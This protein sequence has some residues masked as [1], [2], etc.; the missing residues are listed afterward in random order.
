[1]KRKLLCWYAVCCYALIFSQTPSATCDLGDVTGHIL[2]CG[3]DSTYISGST[4]GQDDNGGNS[5]PDVYY[6]FEST[7]LKTVHISLCLTPVGVDFQLKV[8]SDCSLTNLVAIN[9]DAG[10]FCG[11][12]PTVSFQ[13]DGFSTYVIMVE[14]ADN[15]EGDSEGAF[16][17]ASWCTDPII[18]PPTVTGVTCNIVGS[19]DR[20]VYSE[21]FD[22]NTGWTGDVIYSG[23]DNGYWELVTSPPTQ[24][25]FTGPSAPFS[26]SNYLRYEATTTGGDPAP[27]SASIISQ[28]ID[29]SEYESG[30]ELSFYMHAFG[31]DM[32]TLD[33]NIYDSVDAE[34]D[35]LWEWSGQYQSTYAEDWYEVGIDISSYI[36]Q[37]V[38]LQFIQTRVVGNHGDMSIDLLEITACDS[39]PLNDECSTAQLITDTPYSET[40]D[41]SFAT[42]NT[43]FVTSCSSGMNDGVWYTFTAGASGTIDID[44]TNVI[45]WD[46]AIAVYSGSCGSLICESES[47]ILGV[48]GEE[49]LIAFSVVAGTQYWLNVGYFDSAVDGLEGVF[50]LDITTAP[51]VTLNIGES[52]LNSNDLSV[53]PNPVTDILTLYSN[54]SEIDQVSIFNVLGQLVYN[55]KAN[56]HEIQISVKDLDSGMYIIKTKIGETIKTNK[57]MRR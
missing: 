33:V 51:G 42:N 50:D 53:Y 9:D 43:G 47:N 49:S 38:Q 24:S 37:T 22:S 18:P 6:Y 36:G 11:L 29:L 25:N 56:M 5:S 35:D 45:G 46:V 14:G 21:E 40:I 57:I 23:N 15:P 30:A 8:Y 28:P 39:P 2:T 44:V 34:W 7:E 27:S 13:A 48:G 10:G 20:V 17:I 55:R 19:V 4:I 54:T 1:M 32:G 26:G 3:D 52:N 16:E 12:N 41:A 31:I